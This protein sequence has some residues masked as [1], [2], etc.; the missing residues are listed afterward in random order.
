[1]N[2]AIEIAKNIASSNKVA[3]LTG[4]GIST[5]S[6]IPD[7][8]GPG[9][10]WQRFDPGLLSA[11][12]LINDPRNFYKKG[13][14]VLGQIKKVKGAQPNKAH[15]VLAELQDEKEIDWIITQNIDGLH[16]K[17]GSTKVIE[18]HGNLDKGYCIVCGK[19]YDFT[20]IM[21]LVK[22]GS[23][24]PRC[25]CGGVLRPD[26]VLFGD[27]LGTAYERA[28]SE[29]R[30]SNL[31]LIIGSSL[32]VAPVNHLPDLSHKFIIINREPTVFDPDALLVWHQKA[33]TA[34]LQ[35]YEH[36]KKIKMG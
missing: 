24:P 33:G 35:V 36:I 16:A 27:L 7:F 14:E 12:K 31:L 30:K 19:K 11:D 13:M 23:I 20:Y 1:M 32:E 28:A 34:L 5:E 2:K 3:V 25:D 15:H 10:L 21:D 8:R 9:G 26:V 18:V 4:A 29:V 6:G 22:K 17:A